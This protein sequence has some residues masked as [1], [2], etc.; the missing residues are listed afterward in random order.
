M[1]HNNVELKPTT[2]QLIAKIAHEVNRSVKMF[3]GEE[4]TPNWTD[5]D[6]GMRNRAMIGVEKVIANR[7]ITAAEIHAEWV[8]TMLQDG[9][10]FGPV[11]DT[12]SKR[13]PNLIR[14][15]DLPDT[16]KLKDHLYLAVINGFL[17][18]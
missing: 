8:K 1:E 11:L 6:K 17:S 2:V 5:A 13:H 18:S 10:T 9:W 12:I 7:S 3:Y 16:Q 14:Y 15:E 4:E